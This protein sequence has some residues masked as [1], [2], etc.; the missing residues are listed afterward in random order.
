[1]YVLSAIAVDKLEQCKS[2][3]CASVPAPSHRI[4]FH[5][6]LEY[7]RVLIN[8]LHPL[9]HPVCIASPS[10]SSEASCVFSCL[11]QYYFSLTLVYTSPPPSHS[12]P[13]KVSSYQSLLQLSSHHL[14]HNYHRS[15]NDLYSSLFFPLYVMFFIFP[16]YIFKGVR[17]SVV[18]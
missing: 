17:G 8:L 4:V 10:Y 9:I 6:L 11:L 15:L 1:M 13:S 2:G 16:S 12:F 18:C 14:H 7:V 3:T 5:T